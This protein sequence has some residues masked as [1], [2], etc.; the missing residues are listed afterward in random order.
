MAA[1]GAVIVAEVADV[2]CGELIWVPADDAVTGVGRVLERGGVRRIV[3]PE[4]DRP[5]AVHVAESADLRVVA[6]HHEHGLSGQS[7]VAAR[8]RSATCSSSP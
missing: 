2:R 1:I 5:V 7:A 4:H 6:V 3:D 8:Q